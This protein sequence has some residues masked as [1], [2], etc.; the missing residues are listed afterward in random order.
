M[1]DNGLRL[2]RS[3]NRRTIA[4]CSPEECGDDVEVVASASVLLVGKTRRIIANAFVVEPHEASGCD[5]LG[6]FLLEVGG[7]VGVEHDGRVEQSWTEQRPHTHGER[8]RQ[9]SAPQPSTD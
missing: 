9:D 8:P 1:L 4:E 3:W 5:G 2:R 6:C 7:I